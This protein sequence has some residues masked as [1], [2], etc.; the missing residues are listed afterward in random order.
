MEEIEASPAPMT[1]HGGLVL[2]SAGKNLPYGIDLRQRRRCGLGF[3]APFLNMAVTINAV[4]ASN[5]PCHSRCAVLIANTQCPNPTTSRAIPWGDARRL[6]PLACPVS[7]PG[8]T[9]RFVSPFPAV[10]RLAR[11]PEIPTGARDVPRALRC[12]LQYLKSPRSRRARSAF[13]I[14]S[15]L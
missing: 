15:P 14:A 10:E 2:L 1:Q 5:R 13:V 6:V 12:L 7:E 3:N 8:L 11:N 4:V 9:L